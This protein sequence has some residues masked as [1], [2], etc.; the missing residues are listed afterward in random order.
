MYV[1]RWRTTGHGC[2]AKHFTYSMRTWAS[3]DRPETQSTHRDTVH[4]SLRAPKIW[5]QIWWVELQNYQAILKIE[6]ITRWRTTGHECVTKHATYSMHACARSNMPKIQS[7]HRDTVHLSL[8]APKLW[9][10]IWWELQNHQA[11]LRTEYI[12]SWIITGNGCVAT[13][14]MC[15]VGAWTRSDRPEVQSIH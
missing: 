1:I 11:T 15:L 4:L 6:Y 2:V 13:H 3:Y 7:T 5:N 9:D 14:S 10:Q 12:I 8:R